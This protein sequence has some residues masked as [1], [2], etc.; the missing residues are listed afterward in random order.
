MQDRHRDP[1]TSRV[2]SDRLV[3]HSI[4]SSSKSARRLLQD[5]ATTGATSMLV[6]GEYRTTESALSLSFTAERRNEGEKR[7]RIM[8]RVHDEE[9]VT[10][11]PA[12]T[13]LPGTVRNR[14]RARPS[15]DDRCSCIEANARTRCGIRNCL[16]GGFSID[17]K[18]M[19]Q[20]RFAFGA[21]GRSGCV[22]VNRPCNAASVRRFGLHCQ[23]GVALPNSTVSKPRLCQGI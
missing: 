5:L 12:L 4:S 22:V 13:N 1:V 7:Q 10:K 17:T 8:L 2:S 16:L 23:A 6:L 19:T 14:L 3:F 9:S 15:A 18:P 20:R 11:S 21:W